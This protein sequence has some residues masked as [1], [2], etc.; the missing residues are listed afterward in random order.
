MEEKRS[1]LLVAGRAQSGQG[2]SWDYAVDGSRGYLAL[3]GLG[4]EGARMS[5]SPRILGRSGAPR[6]PERLNLIPFMMMPPPGWLLFG[7]THG[8]QRGPDGV[9]SLRKAHARKGTCQAWAA[10]I[11]IPASLTGPS[12]PWAFPLFLERPHPHPCPACNPPPRS[13]SPLLPCLNM[14]A[15]SAFSSSD[16]FPSS[17][18]GLC[19]FLLLIS[20]V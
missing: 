1:P 18:S 20:T 12:S 6:S 16:A 9:E 2:N 8:N 10:R 5:F 17:S 14:T 3:V 13:P 7:G 15:G 4:V 11:F 19:V